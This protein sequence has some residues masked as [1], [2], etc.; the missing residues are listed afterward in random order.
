MLTTSINGQSV[1]SI[2]FKVV[3]AHVQGDVGNLTMSKCNI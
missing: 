2:F 3:C 1:V